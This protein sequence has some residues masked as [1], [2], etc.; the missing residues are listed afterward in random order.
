MFSARPWTGACFE[1]L[2][3]I[4][5]TSQPATAVL[6]DTSRLI[7]LLVAF[8]LALD[9]RCRRR[10]LAPELAAQDDQAHEHEEVRNELRRVEEG[11]LEREAHR[12]RAGLHEVRRA[13]GADL[14]L[15]R[16]EAGVLEE[17]GPARRHGHGHVAVVHE[18]VRHGDAVVL[19]ADVEEGLEA[20]GLGVDEHPADVREFLLDQ[21][22][23]LVVHLEVV[24][25][26]GE[27]LGHADV[28]LLVLGAEED[29]VVAVHR[30]VGLERDAL[31]VVEVPQRV[32][33][34]VVAHATGDAVGREAARGV[35]RV[36]ALDHDLDRVERVVRLVV[37]LGPRHVAPVL[38]ARDGA[39]LREVLVLG[40]PLLVEHDRAVVEPL[41]VRVPVPPVLELACQR[42]HGV[43]RLHDGD[44]HVVHGV[45]AHGDVVDGVLRAG[46]RVVEPH[47]R[48]E[49]RPWGALEHPRRQ[50]VLHVEHLNHVIVLGCHPLDLARLQVDPGIG[51]SLLVW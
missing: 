37:L 28:H 43:V 33:H 42:V 30:L 48:V 18:G 23:E 41:E 20:A 6:V 10:G 1:L 17:V 45:H 11:Q 29:D 26:G 14:R 3:A 44:E 32:A 21:R 5:A 34:Q 25:D 35:L 27:L 9:G 40:R 24:G 13:V 50:H 16:A 4:D 19:L 31:V 38:G 22:Q 12:L 2:P 7:C 47:A 49:R 46:A 39:E 15:E 51:L 8:A 36:L